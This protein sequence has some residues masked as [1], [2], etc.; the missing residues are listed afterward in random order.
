MVGGIGSW[1][2]GGVSGG[3]ESRGARVFGSGDGF[4]DGAYCC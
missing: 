2:R 1:D 4:V 3:E